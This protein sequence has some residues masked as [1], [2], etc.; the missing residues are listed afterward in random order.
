MDLGK[1]RKASVS[2]ACFMTEFRTAKYPITGPD[3]SCYGSFLHRYIYMIFYFCY[4][5]LLWKPPS[6]ANL[7]ALSSSLRMEMFESFLLYFSFFLPL[8]FVLT[9]IRMR[10]CE[11]EKIDVD[12]L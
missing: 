1:P 5:G 8:L 6:P 11:R 4:S 12:I 3:R 9:H 2:A 10:Q 7:G